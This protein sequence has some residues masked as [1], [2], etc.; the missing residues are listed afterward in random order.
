MFVRPG[1]E[2]ALETWEEVRTVEKEILWPGGTAGHRFKEVW[3]EV[4]DQ[5]GI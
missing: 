3:S 4:A 1:N 2:R 5:G